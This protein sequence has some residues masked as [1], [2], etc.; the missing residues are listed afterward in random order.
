MPQISGSVQGIVSMWSA[1]LT[2]LNQPD[3]IDDNEA[4]FPYY[5][6]ISFVGYK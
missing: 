3:D 6:L 1:E 4:H 5:T 2:Q